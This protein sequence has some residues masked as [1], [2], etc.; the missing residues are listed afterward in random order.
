MPDLGDRA[1]GGVS[2]NPSSSRHVRIFRRDEADKWT[3][4]HANI[5]FIAP[6]LKA[7]LKLGIAARDIR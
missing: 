1:V 3:F 4:V 5:T 7:G 6:Q 2:A